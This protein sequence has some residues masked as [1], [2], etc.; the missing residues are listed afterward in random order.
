V[1]LPAGPRALARRTRG[2]GRT[3]RQG[4]LRDSIYPATLSAAATARAHLPTSSAHLPPLTS[5][6]PS[7]DTALLLN[8]L[9][10]TVAR[11]GEPAEARLLYLRAAGLHELAGL[12]PADPQARHVRDR[13]HAVGEELRQQRGPG[14][15]GLGAA[16]AEASAASGAPVMMDE[17]AEILA[18][19]NAAR[20][21]LEREAAAQREKKLRPVLRALGGGDGGDSDGVESSLVRRELLASKA[22]G[23]RRTKY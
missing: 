6:A 10:A 2:Q 18:A 5:N 11:Q 22:K 14:G 17:A 8:N 21:E 12:S 20:R 9:A 4:P 23:A 16:E 3:L 1:A 15:V 13:L 7:Q 19:A